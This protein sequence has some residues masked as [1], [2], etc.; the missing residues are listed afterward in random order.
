MTELTRT[1]ITPGTFLTKSQV[2]QRLVD[3]EDWPSHLYKFPDPVETPS[4]PRWLA[5]D[6]IRL[7]LCLGDLLV[8]E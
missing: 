8:A 5:D 6:I 2:S 3:F 7:E 1:E 4:G